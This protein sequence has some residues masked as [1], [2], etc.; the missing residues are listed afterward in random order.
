MAPTLLEIL[1]KSSVYFQQK[2]I[3][4]HRLD[5]QLLIGH[6]LGLDRI[7]LYLNFDRPLTNQEVAAC[8]EVVRRRSIRE[9]L[10]HIVGS[11]DFRHLKLKVDK[12][13]LIPRKETEIIIDIALSVLQ[14]IST[15]LT[16]S[17]LNVLD[18]G[19]GA[20]P[21]LLSLIHELQTPVSDNQSD[22]VSPGPQ[23]G[24]TPIQ[25]YGSD[26]S[27]DAITLTKENASY[28]N[29]TL[30][31]DNLYLS[32]EFQS[33]PAELPLHLILSNPPY[34]ALNDK[35]KLQPEVRAFDPPQSLFG[36]QNGTEFPIKL[37]SQA[38][39]RLVPGGHFIMEFG[40]DQSGVLYQHAKQSGWENVKIHPD[41][42]GTDRFISLNKPK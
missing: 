31:D 6:V 3:P 15:H 20:G 21:I 38:F 4:N 23:N 41:Y 9:P 16:V 30:S 10:Q 37:M 42:S 25:F 24:R 28:N 22:S 5:A 29:L 11:V 36:G 12:R 13:A 33:I 35:E 40:F 34:I 14:S 8:R 2:G 1:D 39:S 32:D 18:V 27:K 26:I 19:V 17:T 7:E